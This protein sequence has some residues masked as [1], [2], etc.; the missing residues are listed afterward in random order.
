METFAGTSG[1]MKLSL[2]EHMNLSPLVG[3]LPSREESQGREQRKMPSSSE[4]IPRVLG[5]PTPEIVKLR[6]H[7]H[8]LSCLD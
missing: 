8:F 5:D 3:I 7:L 6:K 2:V 4:D 1:G